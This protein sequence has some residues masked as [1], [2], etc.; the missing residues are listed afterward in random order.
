MRMLL[1]A[2]EVAQYEREGYLLFPGLIDADE[3]RLLQSRLPHLYAQTGP[4]VV[5][6]K[7]GETIRLLYGSHVSDPA[8]GALSVLP[9]LL[10]P[11]CQL[12]GTGAYIHQ[13]RLNPKPAFSGGEW[14]W[15]Q[16]FGT[17][18][19]QDGM[20]RPDAVM[21][22]IF[23]H[24]STPDR[25]PLMV[26]PRTQEHGLVE[27]VTPE[28]AKGYA[29]YQID[30]ATIAAMAD[31]GGIVPLM[32]PAG[33]VAFINCNLVHGSPNNISPWPRAI[34]Y[35]NYNSVE[36]QCTGGQDRA[37]H[38]NNPDKSALVA[39]DDGALRAMAASVSAA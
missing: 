39:G 28:D 23:L 10:D 4:E 27:G 25:G 26:I 2:D 12:L 24:D 6:E 35:I 11:V 36:N 8:Y 20:P 9:R 3:V 37:W 33:T 17:W 32:G 30:R 34:L 29:L 22:A 38:H 15:H 14:Q 5:R 18:H 19:R 7:D 31:K 1:K 21:C 13:S 16:D